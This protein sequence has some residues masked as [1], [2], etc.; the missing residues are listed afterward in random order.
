MKVILVILYFGP[1]GISTRETVMPDM[2]NCREAARAIAENYRGSASG[3]TVFCE[4]RSQW[5]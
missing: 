3:F 4:F 2:P 1:W 5:P